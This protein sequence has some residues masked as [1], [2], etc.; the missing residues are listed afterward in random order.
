MGISGGA[1]EGRGGVIDAWAVSPQKSLD[2]E[3]HFLYL[4]IL[5]S[6]ILNT[7]ETIMGVLLPARQVKDRGL[8]TTDQVLERLKEHGIALSK[9]TLYYY[10]NNGL[11]PQSLK[12]QPLERTKRRF[13]VYWEPSTVDLIVD[14]QEKKQQ[15]FRLSE[16][17]SFSSSPAVVSVFNDLV[18]EV[19]PEKALDTLRWGAGQA[20]TQAELEGTA[21][22]WGLQMEK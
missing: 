18:Q 11:I 19:G 14:L 20:G 16:S 12:G 5:E 3:A 22:K 1:I 7:Q 2:Y 17:V 21:E 15:G 10:R 8:L 9:H 13:Y 4:L 6:K